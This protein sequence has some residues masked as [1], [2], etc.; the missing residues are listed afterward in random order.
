MRA[1]ESGAHEGSSRL[2]PSPCLAGSACVRCVRCCPA[3]LHCCH[4]ILVSPQQGEFET[5]KAVLA[6]APILIAYLGGG[7]GLPV[8]E[9]CAWALGEHRVFRVEV[10]VSVRVSACCLWLSRQQGVH[11]CEA[12]R[13]ATPI[14]V[15]DRRGVAANL[16]TCQ[17]CCRQ[18]CGGGF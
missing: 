15:A 13:Q 17:L 4:H 11:R 10:R 2:H 14:N 18:H 5:V 6:A 16:P 9:Q 3:F 12:G 8:A 1:L 7:S